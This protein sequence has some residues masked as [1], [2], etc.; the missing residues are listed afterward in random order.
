MDVEAEAAGELDLRVAAGSAVRPGS[1]VAYLLP[2]GAPAPEAAPTLESPFEDADPVDF[3]VSPPAAPVEPRPVPFRRTLSRPQPS[4]RGGAW[5]NVFGSDEDDDGGGHVAPAHRFE[6]APSGRG[7][8]V[9][10]EEDI[11]DEPSH[12]AHKDRHS[13]WANEPDDEPVTA[14]G[15]TGLD[16]SDVPMAWAPPEAPVVDEYPYEEPPGPAADLPEPIPFPAVSHDWAP[17]PESQY[18]PPRPASFALSLRATVRMVEARKMRD[19]LARDWR[20]HGVAPENEDIVLRAYAR[21]VLEQRRLRQRGGDGGLVI[22]QGDVEFV[23]VL[24]DAA[25][26]PLRKRVQQLAEARHDQE[27]RDCAFTLTSFGPFGLDEGTPPIPAGHPFALAMGATRA[28]FE[29]EGPVPT[30]VLTLAYTPE[31]MSVGEAAL[32]L[33]RVRELLEAPYALLAD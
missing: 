29:P 17:S 33:A 20:E 22:A 25:H 11:P 23:A 10:D 1:L 16:S 2:P 6:S 9:A 4:S 8:M 12:E 5:D 28:T 19:Q 14:F 31:L 13:H 3:D 24:P 21:A 26:G 18:E 7:W 30:M 32:L 27:P 15:N